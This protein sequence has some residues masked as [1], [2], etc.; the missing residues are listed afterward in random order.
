MALWWVTEALPVAATA[1]V[2][3]VALPLLGVATPTAAAAPFAN[4]VIFLFLGGFLL[5][6]ALQRAG[7]HRRLALAV[8]AAVGTR[9][10]RLVLGFMA[11]TALVSMW[12]SNTATVVMVL[13]LA[14]PVLELLAHDA[15]ADDR[16]R[17]AREAA[18]LLGVAYAASIGGLGTPVGTPPN[19][20]A[21]GFLQATHGV[22][23][24]FAE[25]MR[26]GVPLVL[27]ATPLAWLILTRVAYRVRGRESAE[28]QASVAA[29]RAAL[30]P[31]RRDEW[32]VGLVLVLA[33]AAWV[34]QPLLERALPGLSEAGIGVLAALVLFALPSERG[35]ALLDWEPAERVPWGVLVLFG[36]GLSLAAAVQ[37]SGLAAW[38]GD[39]LGALRGLPLP[40][41]LLLVTTAVVCLTEFTSNTATAAALLPLVSSLALA[42]GTDPVRLAIPTALAASVGFMMPVGTP[43]NAL[44]YATGKVTMRE[45]MRAGA[46]VNVVLVVLVTVV[47]LLVV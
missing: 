16:E 44:V 1:L 11:A 43:P 35:G 5:A 32:L 33:A 17:H 9:P 42:I 31:V 23:I 8:V 41:V 13:P 21:I 7:L 22:R 39:S 28:A 3:L 46:M 14:T 12:V 24:S 40:L 47:G 15:G 30:G 2:P 34:T 37:S 25:W 19:A 18:L 20:L 36:G 26:V 45:M 27:V 29:Q 6:A 38:I 10:D 4:P